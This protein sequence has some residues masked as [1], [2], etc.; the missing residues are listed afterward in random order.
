MSSVFISH[1]E[2]E[3]GLALEIALGLEK[4]GYSTWCYEVDSV[5]GVSYLLQTAQ[6]IEQADVIILIISR[7]SV[8]SHQV[9]REVERGHES[10]KQFVPVLVDLNHVEFQ[11]AQPTW[12]QA[13]GTATSLTISPGD[14]E[15]NSARLASG[16]Q[17]LGIS[18]GGPVDKRRLEVLRAA[19]TRHSRPAGAGTRAGGA[20]CS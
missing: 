7:R 18:P 9:T 11:A 16:L 10:G 13:L 8:T 15:A 19:L 20:M 4:R 1:V 12:R 17:A 14:A 6:A 2:E 3:V 5:P